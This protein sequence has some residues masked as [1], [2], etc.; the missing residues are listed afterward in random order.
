MSTEAMLEM[1]ATRAGKQIPKL[2]ENLF[3]VTRETTEKSNGRALDLIAHVADQF[4]IDSVIKKE[5]AIL[6]IQIKKDPSILAKMTSTI[7]VE[8][9]A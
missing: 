4:P 1:P 2:G 9:I 3:F 7:G 8:Q 5:L 6:K